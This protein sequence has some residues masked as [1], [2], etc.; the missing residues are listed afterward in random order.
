MSD[1]T[2]GFVKA[3]EW[4]CHA[5]TVVAVL[6]E[7]GGARVIVADTSG[8][9]RS[10]AEC[11]KDARRIVACWNACIGMQ[12]P[13]AEIAALKDGFSL[14]EFDA[15]AQAQ[16]QRVSHVEYD[17]HEICKHFVGI[18]RAVIAKAGVQP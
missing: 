18:L 1:H 17:S 15:A 13:E 8:F 10:T 12:D 9:G 11:V 4:T 5:E 16:L 14:A 7:H 6:N 3:I 2:D